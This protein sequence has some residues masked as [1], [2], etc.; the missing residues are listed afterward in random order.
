[1]GLPSRLMDPEVARARP[2]RV[3]KRVD[4]PMPLRPMMAR[5]SPLATEKV[6]P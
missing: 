5:I 4:L 1:M 6:A 2:M 3:L